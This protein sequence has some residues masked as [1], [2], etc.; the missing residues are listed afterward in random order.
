MSNSIHQSL[1]SAWQRQPRVRSTPGGWMSANAVCCHHNGHR[2]D[3][4]GR[5]GLI[6]SSDGSISYSCFNC[7]FRA[8]YRPGRALSYRLRKLLGWL[9]F[10]SNQIRVLI[11]DAIRIRDSAE[12]D[13]IEL[14][15]E[16]EFQIRS[17]PDGCQSF[18]A[19]ADFYALK[20]IDYCPKQFLDAVDYVSQRGID[21]S[22]YEFYW[23]DLTQKHW[24]N[25]IVIPFRHQTKTVGYTARSFVDWLKPRYLADTQPGYVFNLDQQQKNWRFVIVCEGVFDA[26]SI[27]GCAVMH[28]EI[29][30]TQADQID[31]LSRD[32]IVVPDWDASGRKLLEQAI[33]YNWAVSFPTW[34][35]TCKDINDAVGRYGKL[36]VLKDILDHVEHSGLKIQLWDRRTNWKND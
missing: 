18:G 30:E 17:L 21:M 2:P 9:G 13:K 24:N 5:G 29:S 3:T 12:F 22:R 25:R 11:L 15:Q 19:W 26:M 33:E 14:E 16:V 10:D 36:F 1:L 4:R 35:E 32:I 6:A 31:N 8:H 20:G 27:D 7:G 34:R 28:N 23:T